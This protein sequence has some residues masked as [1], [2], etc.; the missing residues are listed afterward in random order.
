M[1]DRSRSA[2]LAGVRY[3]RPWVSAKAVSRRS[4]SPGGRRCGRG[5]APRRTG[6]TARCRRPAAAAGSPRVVQRHRARG[7]HLHGDPGR[8]GAADPVEGPAQVAPVERAGRVVVGAQPLGLGQHLLGAAGE[9]L[10]HRPHQGQEPGPLVEARSGQHRAGQLHR[11]VGEDGHLRGHGVHQQVRALVG[12]PDRAGARRVGVH[13]VH[14]DVGPAL[15]GGE[16][17]A[18]PLQH[19][20]PARP[21]ADDAQLCVLPAH[22]ASPVQVVSS[23]PSPSGSSTET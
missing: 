9:G 18:E 3:A 10:V 22:P 15:A 16:L 11:V 21:G 8:G 14:G 6:P 13:D 12:A 2:G 1:K 23:T 7:V 4:V 5:P 19:G 17:G 20:E